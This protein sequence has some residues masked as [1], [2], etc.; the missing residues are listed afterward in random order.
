MFRQKVLY[1]FNLLLL[2][3]CCA[4]NFL[5]SYTEIDLYVQ[6]NLA[7][8]GFVLSFCLWMIGI[9]LTRKNRRKNID[10]VIKKQ[11]KDLLDKYF[12]RTNFFNKKYF[13]AYLKSKDTKVTP[14]D[15]KKANQRAKISLFIF[16]LVILISLLI[17]VCSWIFL[18][19]TKFSSKYSFILSI[20]TISEDILIFWTIILYPLVLTF[21]M[22]YWKMFSINPE[23]IK[24]DKMSFFFFKLFFFNQSILFSDYE[25]KY[26]ELNQVQV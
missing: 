2:I 6:L 17:I 8:F 15:L 1:F 18:V 7:I 26:Q 4:T 20:I 19:A 13:S 12:L 24:K 23:M 16:V 5:V 22:A 11:K 25:K 9:F 21:E 14:E 3:I 10:F